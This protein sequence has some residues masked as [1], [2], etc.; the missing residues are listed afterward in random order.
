MSVHRFSIL[1]L[2][3]RSNGSFLTRR[4]KAKTLD[5]HRKLYHVEKERKREREN[6]GRNLKG[7]TH[8]H[9]HTYTAVRLEEREGGTPYGNRCRCCIVRAHS[10]SRVVSLGKKDA[11]GEGE[12]QSTVTPKRSKK[13]KKQQ[14]TQKKRSETKKNR[15]ALKRGEERKRA[16]RGQRESAFVF[17]KIEGREGREGQQRE[18]ERHYD[19]Q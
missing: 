12:G 19:A 14:E 18:R 4:S 16:M 7:R 8:P 6:N 17:M 10:S 15:R 2:S 3:Q 11:A 9:P 5:V 1:P 13:K